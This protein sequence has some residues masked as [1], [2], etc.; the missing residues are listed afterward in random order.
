LHYSTVKDLSILAKYV[1]KYEFIKRNAKRMKTS[2]YSKNWR[3]VDLKNTN[4]LLSDEV[5]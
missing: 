3:K 2:I 5:V 1:Y 4:I